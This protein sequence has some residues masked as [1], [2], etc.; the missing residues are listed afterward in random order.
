MT[1]TLASRLPLRDGHTIPVLGLGVYMSPI[2]IET[3][4]A[5]RE[6]LAVG[7]R[8]I[9]TARVYGNEADVGAGVRESGVPRS[10]VFLTTKLW[11][12]DHGYDATLRAC[13]ASLQQLGVDYLDLYLIHWPVPTLRHD[14]WRA[15]V[16]LQRQGLAR[17][18]GVSNYTIDHLQELMRHSDVLPAVNQV[19]LHPF[20]YQ[21]EL[22]HFCGER[23]I[24]VEAYSPLTRGERLNHPVLVALG[25]E[26][27]KSAAQIL[28]RWG[29]Q[30]GLVVLPKSTHADRIRENAEV[31]DV[32][33]TGAE[34]ASL[35][36]LHEDLRTCWDPSDAP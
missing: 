10:E 9:D 30:H 2:G 6:A 24:M 32:T 21:H 31:F 14:T 34:M 4:A 22:L 3:Q 5:V 29:L 20:L 18:I 16:E 13:E 1:L 15:F 17:S 36:A 7:Y 23:Q 28:I 26:H 11:N 12:Q 35:D 25:A 8:H 19:E 27:G 33:L